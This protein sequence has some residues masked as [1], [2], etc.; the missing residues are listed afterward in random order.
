MCLPDVPHQAGADEDATHRLYFKS[1]FVGSYLDLSLKSNHIEM[2]S[3][4]LSVVTIIK[5]TIT[6]ESKTRKIALDIKADIDQSTALAVI[7]MLHPKVQDLFDLAKKVQLID[8]LK[9]LQMHEQDV[10]FLSDECKMIL[11]DANQIKE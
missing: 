4:N 8:G 3:D 9:E 10:S 11:R 5:D 7:D 1:A 2:K 6:A